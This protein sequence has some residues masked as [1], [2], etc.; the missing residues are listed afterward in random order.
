MALTADEQRRCYLHLRVLQVNRSG[1]YVGGQPDTISATHRL[2]VALNNVT[3]NGEASV[4]EVLAT[5]DSLRAALGTMD[6]RMQAAE[7]RDIVL[8][9]KELEQRLAHYDMWRME[10][11]CVL[12]VKELIAQGGALAGAQGPWREP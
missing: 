11:A 12:D 9:P 7:V 5:L 4:R 8:N 2:Q 1:V 3:A 10:L 6:T